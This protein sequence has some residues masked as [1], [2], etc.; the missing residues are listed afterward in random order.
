MEKEYQ[1]ECCNWSIRYWI[2]RKIQ[3]GKMRLHVSLF[4]LNE[5]VDSF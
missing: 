1:T 2:F 4:N 3:N 5:M